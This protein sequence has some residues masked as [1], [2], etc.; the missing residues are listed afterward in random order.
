MRSPSVSRHYLQVEPAEDLARW[1][2]AR[3]W[4]ELAL[5][6]ASPGWELAEGPVLEKGVTELRS[7]VVEPMR[8]GR[9]FLAGDAAHIV[10]ATGA[11]GLNLAV[12]DVVVLATA[13]E[14]FF[15][16]GDEQGLEEYS[17][18]CLERVWAV[19]RFSST[20]TDLLHLDPRATPFDRRLQ[21]SRLQ[22]VLTSQ[23]AAA[24]LAEQ[25]VGLPLPR[26]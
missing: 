3:I 9:L 1:P 17:A 14:R 2:D 16:R 4:E 25:Y 10:P 8:R 19:Q 21:R 20:M 7:V 6:L 13:L 12:A 24:D 18:R 15:H 11:K 23:V 26:W 5:R 22:H